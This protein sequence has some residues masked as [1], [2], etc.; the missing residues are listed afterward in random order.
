VAIPDSNKA[1]T[2]PTALTTAQLWREV[3]SLK[4]LMQAK[5]DA[6]D[7]A[8]VIAHD[9]LVRVPTETQ[10]AVGNLRDLH[11]EKLA[12]IDAWLREIHQ[13][14]E[15]KRV[16]ITGLLMDVARLHTR[17]EESVLRSN[18]RLAVLN[19]RVDEVVHQAAGNATGIARLTSEAIAARDAMNAM[20]KA[21]QE[22]ISK[23]EIANEKRFANVNEFR[24]QLGD[25]AR[26]FMPRAEV[27]VILKTLDSRIDKVEERDIERIGLKSGTKEGWLY[28]L[29]AFTIIGVV[30]AMLAMFKNG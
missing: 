5:L 9:D 14:L 22:A 24:A 26:T 6:M 21:Q 19:T 2:D 29:G 4:E 30:L 7:R 3:S 10:K 23:A 1:P 20:Y 11:D 18:E 27:E 8:I 16:T 13:R 12:A 28:A 17:G 25:Q 15:N